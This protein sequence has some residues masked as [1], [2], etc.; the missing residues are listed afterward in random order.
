MF[1]TDEFLSLLV[2]RKEPKKD[3][4]TM[5]PS[6]QAVNQAVKARSPRRDIHVATGLNA[7]SMALLPHFYSLVY[8]SIEKGI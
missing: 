8:G 7:P 2:Q 3:T 4:P 5:L 6:G 1:V